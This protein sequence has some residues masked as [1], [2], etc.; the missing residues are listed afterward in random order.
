MRSTQFLRTAAIAGI[1]LT[2]QFFSVAQNR[3]DQPPPS[4]ASAPAPA[5]G[6]GSLAQGPAAS[7]PPG[8]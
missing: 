6:K 8:S 1:F 5:A 7:C 4:P 2:Q 3:R